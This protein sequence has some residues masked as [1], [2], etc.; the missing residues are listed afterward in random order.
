MTSITIGQTE[1]QNINQPSYF[2]TLNDIKYENHYSYQ[3]SKTE[4]QL[5]NNEN[6][7]VYTFSQK[8]NT[9]K[10]VKKYDAISLQI[11]TLPIEYTLINIKNEN[12]KWL[13]D[14][15]QNTIAA[16]IEKNTITPTFIIN[17]IKTVSPGHYEASL[18]FNDNL[19]IKITWFFFAEYLL[20]YYPKLIY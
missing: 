5:I 3:I 19:K 10:F 17:N 14:K 7:D 1:Y 13:Q 4:L 20:H 15:E 11:K 9:S 12:L 8:K 16:Y 6:N 2:K 18:I